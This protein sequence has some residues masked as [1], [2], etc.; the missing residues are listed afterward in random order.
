MGCAIKQLAEKRLYTEFV[1]L[2]PPLFN[3]ANHTA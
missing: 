1:K 2:E 3:R